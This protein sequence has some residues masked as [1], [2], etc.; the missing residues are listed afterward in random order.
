MLACSKANSIPIITLSKA[1][2]EVAHGP[3]CLRWPCLLDRKGTGIFVQLNFK[4]SKVRGANFEDEGLWKQ[5][6]GTSSVLIMNY[7]IQ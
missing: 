4:L 1:V 2:P 6:L 3:C 7:G 5:T